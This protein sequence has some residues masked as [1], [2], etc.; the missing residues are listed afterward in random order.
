MSC[1][2]VWYRLYFFWQLCNSLC[3]MTSLMTA[4][5]AVSLGTVLEENHD[6]YK[7]YIT[8]YIRQLNTRVRIDSFLFPT[9]LPCVLT[10]SPPPLYTG[11]AGPSS[12]LPPLPHCLCVC[13]CCYTPYV[14]V[15]ISKMIPHP[16]FFP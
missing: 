12:Y 7:G 2:C 15:I 8:D 5:D 16:N 4:E 6:T 11:V 9:P 10:P 1:Y 14:T 13:P 3:H